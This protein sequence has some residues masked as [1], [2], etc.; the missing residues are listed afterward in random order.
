MPLSSLIKN[1]S[2]WTIV[3]ISDTH[4][5]DQDDLEFAAMNPEHS[6]QDVIQH[7]QQHLPEIDAIVHT[8]DLAQ[9][10][11][12]ATYERYLRFM[13]TLNV[14]H[15][16]IPGNHDD[17][18]IFPFYRQQDRAHML[19]FGNWRII[20]LNSAVAGKVD[21]WVAEKQLQE[22]DLLLSEQAQQHVVIACHHHPFAMKSAW[23]D[24][25][26]LKNSDD[27]LAVIAKHSN[28]KAV[29]YGHVHQDSRNDLNGVQ[30][31]STPS[32]SV[33]FKPM[34]DAFALD[35]SFPGYRVLHLKA[36]G[37][38][39]SEVIRVKIDQPKINVEISGY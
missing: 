5:M 6:F 28:V 7:M 37:E 4:L 12:A 19:S 16:Q 31:L 25:H 10:P 32:T 30:F 14:P 18:A 20:L 39:K 38:F 9:V 17:T 24:Q 8:G 13:Q 21:G 15:F 33:Q 22:L 26:K 27:L 11:V 36:N 23:I 3:Q 29:L 1:E 34:S 2:D 35:E